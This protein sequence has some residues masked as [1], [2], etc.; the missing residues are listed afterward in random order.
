MTHV[1]VRLRASS[2]LDSAL[3]FMALNQQNR[4]LDGS[5][6]TDNVQKV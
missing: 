6:N 1:L 5:N 4:K 2:L 3:L